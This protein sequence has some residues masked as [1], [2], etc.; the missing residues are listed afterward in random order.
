M[1]DS[2][3]IPLFE[4][5]P[6]ID[7]GLTNVDSGITATRLV[8]GSR[9]FRDYNWLTQVRP[10]NISGNY[11]GMV[12][13]ARWSTAFRFLDESHKVLEKL[14]YFAGFVANLAEAAPKMEAVYKLKE[15]SSTKGLRYA[16]IAGTAAQRTL[17]GVVPAGVHLIY[18]SLEGW[19]MMA[20][21]LGGPFQSGSEQAIK[22]IDSAD[23]LVQ[24]T[25]MTV[26]D[27]QNQG[28][29]VWSV[30]DIVVSSRN[31]PAADTDVWRPL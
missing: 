5:L 7:R 1:A 24:S 18:R 12:I 15:P 26:T 31:R 30:I 16:A 11:R 4:I 29:V 25:F 8:A 2:N 17:I 6:K 19:C 10:T 14:G 20:G 21:L 9:A 22:V 28:N 13:N 27:T 23:G 3:Q